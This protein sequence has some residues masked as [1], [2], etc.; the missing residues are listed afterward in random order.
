[1][2]RVKRR[3]STSRRK[4]KA[5]KRRRVA[6]TATGVGKSVVNHL[7]GRA[8][9]APRPD[10]A[11]RRFYGV[12]RPGMAMTNTGPAKIKKNTVLEQGNA[13]HFK[14]LAKRLADKTAMR[15]GDQIVTDI[16]GALKQAFLPNS[17]NVTM[18]ILKTALHAGGAITGALAGLLAIETGPLAPVI[19]GTVTKGF[20]KL[21][22]SLLN[23]T[24]GEDEKDYSKYTKDF[25]EKYFID[26]RNDQLKRKQTEIELNTLS[27]R[28][29]PEEWIDIDLNEPIIPT[30]VIT[31]P[32]RRGNLNIMEEE[33]PDDY[34]THNLLERLD[35]DDEIELGLD[36]FLEP[37][38][39]DLIEAVHNSLQRDES[40]D[41]Y[42]HFRYP[43]G[44]KN[45]QYI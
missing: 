2:P 19:G 41:D 22:D 31:P 26:M 13:A 43:P 9:T 38:E 28:G 17:K 1:M 8:P 37:N 11:L 39:E 5:Y 36:E 33:F 24:F 21:S 15:A 14:N 16:G 30:R 42:G 20:N 4:P 27:Q 32:V 23:L 12:Q 18:D 29:G 3:R 7:M 34:M 6:S 40:V 45:Y 44:A 10:R 35:I 25:M